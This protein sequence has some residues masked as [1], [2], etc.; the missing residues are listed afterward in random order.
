[1][2]GSDWNVFVLADIRL[3][4]EEKKKSNHILHLKY[5]GVTGEQLQECKSSAL[6]L[7][8]KLLIFLIT[9]R[10]LKLI[11]VLNPYTEL[12]NL[13]FLNG[14]TTNPKSVLK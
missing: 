6:F 1:M 5:F 14:L 10:N 7:F 3:T 9:L 13:F 11:S 4:L 2:L 8:S 12:P